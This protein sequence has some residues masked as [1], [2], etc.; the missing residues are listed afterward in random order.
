M[1]H[2]KF[3]WIE[4]VHAE[5]RFTISEKL[6]LSYCATFGVFGKRHD[7]QLHQTLIAERVGCNVR[8]VKRTFAKARK[9]GYLA[10][11]EPRK[12]GRGKGKADRNRIVMPLPLPEIGDIQVVNRGHS[13]T[14]IGDICD[15][16]NAA[17]PPETQPLRLKERLFKG[18]GTL[19]GAAP[20][21]CPDHPDGPRHST[22]CVLCARVREYES[23][24][25]TPTPP[26]HVPQGPP[27]VTTE[28][29]DAAR[30][31]IRRALSKRGR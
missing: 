4:C 10:V 5:T 14:E 20:P 19:R 15:T 2:L 3:A 25:P 24:R 23:S 26:R 18:D 6:I 28:V 1:R 27:P 22:R 7:F 21:P 11:A 8:T 31:E 9:L 12:R 13:G 17:S 30:A 16:E 29:A